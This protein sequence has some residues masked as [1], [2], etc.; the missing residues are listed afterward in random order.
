MSYTTVSISLSNGQKEKLQR[1]VRKSS[2]VSLRLGAKQT[3]GSD[4]LKVTLA[5]AKR[6]EKARRNGTGLDLKLSQ[7]GIRKQVGAGWLS[8]LL[9]LA[10]S[11]VLPLAK[12]AVAP[13]AT[14]ALSGIRK[15][16]FLNTTG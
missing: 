9:P 10:K 3:T 7:T 8:A 1:S 12:K 16:T 5:Q 13:L 15:G 2:P 4:E 6:L 14:G 11:T